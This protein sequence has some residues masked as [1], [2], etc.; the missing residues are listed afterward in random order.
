MSVASYAL[1]VPC[2]RVVVTGVPSVSSAGSSV[3]V[4]GPVESFPVTSSVPPVSSVVT[5]P[6]RAVSIVCGE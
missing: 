1:P 5:G 4:C 2:C 3:A 6:G